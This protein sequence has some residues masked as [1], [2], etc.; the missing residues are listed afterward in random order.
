[1]RQKDS[2]Q[3]HRDRERIILKTTLLVPTLNEI[4]GMKAIMPRIRPEWVDQIVVLDGQSTDGTVEYAQDQGYVVHVQRRP[5]LRAGLMDVLPYLDGEIIVT[6]SPDGNCI[7]ETIPALIAKM[8]AGFDMVIASRYL[9]P[10]RSDDDDILTAFGNWFF[11]TSVNLLHRAHY[12]DMMVMFRAFRKELIS[13]LDLDKEES[14]ATPERLFRTRI[15][16]EPLLSIRASK[17][18]LKIAEIPGHEPPRIGGQRKLQIWKW[19][20]AYYYQL[21]RELVCWQAPKKETA[22]SPA[23]LPLAS[24]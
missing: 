23:L 22:S 3:S 5:G 16:W 10:A 8:H 7:P 2:P 21:L 4:D 11:T 19:G 1:M 15:G 13:V 12:T 14:Y 17:A 24:V 18:R 20:A 6:F 9:P